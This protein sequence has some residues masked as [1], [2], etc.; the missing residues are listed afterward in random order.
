MIKSQLRWSLLILLILL[1]ALVTAEE[2]TPVRRTKAEQSTIELYKRAKDAVVF[3]NTVTLTVDPDDFFA[4]VKPQQGSGTGIIVDARRGII[5]TNLHVIKNARQIEILLSDGKP[6]SAK[7]LGYDEEFDIAVLQLVEPPANLTALS[8]GNSDTVEVGQSVYAI[9]NPFGLSQ[10]LTSGIV[11]SLDRAVRNSDGTVMRGLIQT[12]AAINPGN[13]G[14]PL[15]DSAGNLIGVNTA[16]LSQSGDSAGI[17]F[18]VPSNLVRRILPELIVNG[19][20]LR[21]KVGWILLNTKYGPMVRRVLPRGPADRAGVRGIE[22]EI[23]R[24]PIQMWVRDFENA[25]LIV[26]V[27]SVRVKNSDEVDQAVQATPRGQS[28][29]FEV[30][31]G[32]FGEVR[33]VIITP[34]LQ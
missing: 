2:P 34:V 18:A 9:G 11:S 22:N 25:D 29:I 5:I 10:T 3:I 14:G 8:F 16:I 26:S 1:S 4:H 7:L 19:K 30:R 6:R 28:A 21:P 13:S 17:G 20:I 33:K 23:R 27:N 31:S 32:P 12:D 15:L 24:G